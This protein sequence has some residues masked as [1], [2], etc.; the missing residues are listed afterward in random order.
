MT[1]HAITSFDDHQ[2]IYDNQTYARTITTT[3]SST[4]NQPFH[5]Y[6]SVLPIPTINICENFLYNGKVADDVGSATSSS[7]INSSDHYDNTY[8]NT[9]DNPIEYL[10]N[11]SLLLTRIY[12]SK[13]R[14]VS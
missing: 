9:Y 1:T 5:P 10:D 11:V 4:I 6:L 14:F 7:Y 2:M 3:Y 8:I 13:Y 12:L